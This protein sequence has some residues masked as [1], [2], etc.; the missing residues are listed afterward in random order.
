MGMG[1]PTKGA[2]HRRGF[3]FASSGYAS[4]FTDIPKPDPAK[5]RRMAVAYLDTFDTKAWYTDPVCSILNG[6]KLLAPTSDVCITKN[7]LNEPNGQQHLATPDQ[8]TSLLHHILTYHSPHTDLRPQ[9]RRIEQRFLTEYAGLLVGN[10]CLD[11][12]KQD[13]VTEIEESVMANTIERR[14]NDQLVQ[15]EQAGHVIIARKPIYV[16]CVS[17]FSNFLDLF[18]KTLRSL[19]LGIPCVIL[20]RSHTTQHPYRW[21]E[22]LVEL[23]KD[24]GIPAGMVTYLSCRLEDIVYITTQSAGVAGNLYTTCSRELAKTI[25]DGYTDT[26]SSTGGPNTLLVTEWTRPVQDA[27]RMSAS[28]ECAGQCTALRHLV[29]PESVKLEDV[30]SMFDDVKHVSSPPVDALREGAFDGVFAGHDGTAPPMIGIGGDGRGVAYTKHGQKDAYFR[31]GTALPFSDGKEVN[32]YW[33]KVVI[34]VTNTLPDTLVDNDKQLRSVVD[35]LSRWLIRHQPISLAVNSKRAQ[36]LKIGRTLFEQTSLVVTTI[37]STDSS[38]APP[39]MTCQARPQDAEC[40]G[41]FPPRKRMGEYTKFPVIIPS[42]TPS[43]DTCYTNEYLTSRTV[44]DLEG[45]KCPMYVKDWLLDITNATTRGYCIEV[46]SYLCDATEQNPKRGVAGTGRTALWGLQRPPLV[47]RL[48]TL[49]VCGPTVTFDDLSSIFLVFYSTNAQS[50]VELSIDGT[51]QGLLEKITKHAINDRVFGMVVEDEEM[52]QHRLSQEGGGGGGGG[53]DDVY[54]N[55]VR[56]PS[57]HSALDMSFPMPGQFVSLYLP[58]GHIKSTQKDDEE[59][60]KYFGLSEKWLKM[61]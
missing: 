22:L 10:Q 47:E 40:F 14:L 17:N 37:G 54:Y 26:I 6:E 36:S 29:V 13:G 50:Q 33:R 59:F 55:I 42:S 31:V 16:S 27:V 4:C 38:D 8:V 60:V 32:E 7:S 43:Y 34:D 1:T 12:G 15:K 57:G 49:L 24:E 20:G 35:S 11:F 46:L 5:I 23:M 19:E 18:R 45:T 48:R 9:V 52:L 41:E 2:Q 30:R 58:L 28:I 51:N 3:N 39:A 56:V 53:D 61:A 44:H 21:T 25:K